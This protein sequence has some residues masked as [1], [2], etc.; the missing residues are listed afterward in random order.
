MKVTQVYELLNNVVGEVTGKTDLVQEDL[1]NVIDVGNE[2]ID[3]DNV[4]N[5]VKKLVNHIGKVI[6]DDRIYRGNVP[7]V[8]MDSW[9][10]G[11]I[12]EKITADLPKAN[13]NNSWELEDGKTYNQDIFYQPEISAKFFNSK[14]TFEI[15]ISFSQ[16]QVKESFKSKS[17]LNGFF[18][19]IFTSVEN[20]MTLQLDN[21]V[22]RTIN[23]MIA[24]T[25]VDDLAETKKPGKVELKTTESGVKAINLLKLY[26]DNTGEN[27]T[28]DMAY[29]NESF[30]RFSSYIISLYKD[31]LTKVTTLFNVGKKERFT[32]KDK[33]VVVLLS[34]Y[35]RATDVFLNSNTFN[36]ELVKLPSYETVPYWQGIGNSYD[37]KD[38]SRIHL[39]TPNNY[40][41]EVSGIIGVIFDVASIGV[42]NLDRRVTT[43]FN[44][45]G[46]FYT[47]FYKMDSGYFNDL[48]ENFIVFFIG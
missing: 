46:E 21:L 22:M 4:D 35:A 16:R 25:I 9:E 6:F 5:Y 47:N 39:K 18:S 23:N 11:S 45:K 1:S 32:P 41:V 40:E 8:I 7:S 26:N 27:L 20:S 42:T 28:K 3:T 29:T 24:E 44:A 34:D 48:N 14:V 43:N 37:F 13:V 33:S 15:P 30:I 10:Y 19:M 38:V 12:L 17:Q 31:R 2:I 36:N